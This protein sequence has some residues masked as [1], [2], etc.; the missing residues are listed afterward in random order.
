MEQAVVPAIIAAN[1][2]Q[3]DSMLEKLHF[4][5]ALH[6]DVMDGQFV[7]A[8]SLNFAPVLSPAHTYEVH[9]MVADPF[10]GSSSTGDYLRF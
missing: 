6:L 3:L 9:L 4:S 1:Q 8:T 7:R 10:L 5:K 2:E